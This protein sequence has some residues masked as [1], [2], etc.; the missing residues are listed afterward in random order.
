MLYPSIFPFL[1][2]MQ[3]Y[4]AISSDISCSECRIVGLTLTRQDLYLKGPR[5]I[6]LPHFWGTQLFPTARLCIDDA[7]RSGLFYG[8]S[9][10]FSVYPRRRSSS[11]STSE[12]L[13][14]GE[15]VHVGV[16]ISCGSRGGSRLLLAELTINFRTS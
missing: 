13:K 4:F 6:A 11:S 12:R 10:V 2:R 14:D 15:G 5:N 1:F 3:N 8:A 7:R 9:L 16:D